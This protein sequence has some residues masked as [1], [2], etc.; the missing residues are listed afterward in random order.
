LWCWRQQQGEPT[1]IDQITDAYV[2]LNRSQTA[3]PNPKN[4][5]LY[6][7]LQALQDEVSQA[8]RPAFARHRKFVAKT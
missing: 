8:L 5:A 7:E 3:E 2:T 1:P 4:V 6:A